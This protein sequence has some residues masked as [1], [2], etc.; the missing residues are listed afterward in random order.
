MVDPYESYP[1][2]LKQKDE[3]RIEQIVHECSRISIEKGTMKESKSRT[4]N[5]TEQLQSSK[6]GNTQFGPG[7]RKKGTHFNFRLNEIVLPEAFRTIQSSKSLLY[8]DKCQNSKPTRTHHCQRCNRCTIRM[9]HHC[10]WIGT[11]VGINNYKYFFLTL[12]YYSS[13]NIYTLTLLISSIL[14]KRYVRSLCE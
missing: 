4:S 12:V 7:H 6:Q 1:K 11:C 3:L 5:P 8:C 9:D 2:D 13:Y 10:P 14:H